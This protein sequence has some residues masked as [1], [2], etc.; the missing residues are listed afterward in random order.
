MENIGKEIPVISATEGK[1]IVPVGDRRY[2]KTNKLT[3]DELIVAFSK[4]KDY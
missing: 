1:T 3:K 2:I 4:G